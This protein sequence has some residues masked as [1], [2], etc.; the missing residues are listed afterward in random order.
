[1]ASIVLSMAFWLKP[2]THYEL[3]L[4]LLIM[5]PLAYVGMGLLGLPIYLWLKRLQHLTW[6][7]FTRWGAGAGII[8]YWLLDAV[9]VLLGGSW[10]FHGFLLGTVLGLG[11]GF[12]V[13]ATF[14]LIAGVPFW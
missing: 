1:M 12:T 8:L 14:A 4:T 10:E 13:A 6:W 7:S 2:L 11:V 5:V 3:S 9:I